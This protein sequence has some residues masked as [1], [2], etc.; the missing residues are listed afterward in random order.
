[1]KNHLF[2]RLLPFLLLGMGIVAFVFGIIL[3]AYLLMFG[4]IIG[5]VLFILTW[6][7]NKWFAPPSSMTVKKTKEGRIIDS[8]DWRKL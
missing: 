1:M 7:R 2:E 5:F 4:A 8:D 6:I 3:F